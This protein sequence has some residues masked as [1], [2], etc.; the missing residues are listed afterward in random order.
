MKKNRPSPSS[1]ISVQELVKYYE[2]VS[3]KSSEE[4][5][6]HAAGTSKK[7][8]HTPIKENKKSL[9]LEE[10]LP[11][12]S[13]EHTHAS[14]ITP[15]STEALM[16][17]KL[18]KENN[19][20]QTMYKATA[21][22]DTTPPLSQ[23]EVTQLIAYDPWII[24]YQREISY[25][26]KE[27]FGK[28]DIL[29][30]QINEIQKTPLLWKDLLWQLEENPKSIHGFAGINVCGIKNKT[31]K[32]AERNLTILCQIVGCYANAVEN[33]KENL[34]RFPQEQLERYEKI[35]G[36]EEMSKILQSQ[37]CSEKGGETLTN[38]EVTHIARQNSMVKTHQA[39][40]AH[41]S[42]VVFGKPD[43]LQGR[44]ENILTI[45]S[46]GFGLIRQLEVDPS[47][48]HKLSGISMCGFKSN[49]RKN[50]EAHIPQLVDSIN[51]FM[52]VV[53]QEKENIL[54]NHQAQQEQIESSEKFVKSLHKQQD[55][56]RSSESLSADQHHEVPGTSGHTHERTQS[57]KL[58]K[59]L[60][61]KAFALAS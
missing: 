39:Q 44:I 59:T 34:F 29:Q 55:L 22:K 57:A 49:A 54:Q 43:I 4:E 12:S 26:C 37:H 10:N 33:A 32:N 27:V 58:R 5:S 6:R 35:I 14:V 52:D 24:E 50:A 40:I 8:Q 46:K 18:L 48:L 17:K 1:R 25:W 31:R 11:S 30:K 23:A 45:P 41:L 51:N 60:G 47:S 20:R 36:S 53:K 13:T 28:K 2:E 61:T 56:S 38:T 16:K 21:S 15:G 7:K 3:R 9:F 42:G 19:K